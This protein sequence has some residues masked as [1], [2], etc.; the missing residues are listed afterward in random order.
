MIIAIVGFSLGGT[1]N[2]LSGL[3]VMELVKVLPPALKSK[4][5]GFY[6]AVT[7]GVGNLT[8]AFTQVLIGFVI[9]KDDEKKVFFVFIV[10]AG[11]SVACLLILTVYTYLKKK[12]A[13]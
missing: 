5:L 3:I 1:F 12:A 2:T 10:Y 8:T 6:S 7:M 9:G 13:K 11:V 4:R